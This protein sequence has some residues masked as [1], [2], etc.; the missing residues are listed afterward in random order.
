MGYVYSTMEKKEYLAAMRQ[1]FDNPLYVFDE[2]VTGF[3]MGPF[4]AAAHYQPWEWN[5]K[6][7]SECNR[8]YGIVREKDGKLEIRFIRS[9]GLLSPFWF[10]FYTLL[11]QGMCWIVME[12]N[13][14]ELGNV[15]W[16]ISF[17]VAAVVCVIT[18]V[19]SSLTENGQA[20][21]QEVYRFLRDPKEYY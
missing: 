8:A 21:E 13:H 12:R 3:V 20:G 19:E 4:F 15:T 17:A 7:T 9:K 16:L 10:A 1:R 11:C 14:M 5:R 6:I 18:A 2:R